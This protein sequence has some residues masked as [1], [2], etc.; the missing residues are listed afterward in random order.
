MPVTSTVDESLASDAVTNVPVQESVYSV[1]SQAHPTF[2]FY[3]PYT[4]G[5]TP[6]EFVLQDEQNNTIYQ[7]RFTEAADEFGVISVALPETA[8][9][10]EAD[11]LYHWYF[12]AYCDEDNP[13]FVEGWTE[14][15]ALDADL[16][17][18]LTNAT[19]REQ[20]ALYAENGIWQE[21]STLLG[22]QYRLDEDNL[23][24]TEDWTSLLTSVDLGEIA[25]QP[26]VDCCRE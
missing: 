15:I 21:A 26:M 9:A 11:T 10:L 18:A 4:L 23:N 17:D 3:V 5:E 25:L 13:T 22:E 2:W 14:R 6:V 20:V 19:A 24:L 8:P 16:T 7:R 1:T 12:M